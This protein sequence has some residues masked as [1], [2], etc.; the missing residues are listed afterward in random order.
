[1]DCNGNPLPRGFM[2]VPRCT[3]VVYLGGSFFISINEEWGDEY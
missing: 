2:G 3:Y 1:M